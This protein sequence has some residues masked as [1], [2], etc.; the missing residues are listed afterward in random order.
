MMIGGELN[1]HLRN[2]SKGLPETHV[3]FYAANLLL[4]LE[5]LHDN[6]YVH[7]DLKPENILLNDKG[8]PH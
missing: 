8:S 7:R 3:Q 1:F 2:S 4:A 5:Y 6:E